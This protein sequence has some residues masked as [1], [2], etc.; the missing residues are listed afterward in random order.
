MRLLDR[1]IFRQVFASCLGAI[2][3]FTFV[4][5]T[6]NVLKQLLTLLLTG[7]LTFLGA[8]PLIGLLVPFVV[9]YT[10][11]MGL[12]CG[13]LLVL[14]RLSAESETVAMRAAGLSL[15]RI[16]APIYALAIAAGIAAVAINLYYMP[17][18]ITKQRQELTRIVR[19]D[20]LKM[21]VPKTFVRDFKN[22]VVYVTER[23]GEE[24]RDVWVWELDKEQRVS[25][26]L[27][28]ESGRIDLDEANNQL[29]ITLNHTSA[30]VRS[31]KDPE[32][33][34][35]PPVTA[36]FDTTSRAISLDALFG[37]ST[38]K[39]K[40]DWF[41][42]GELKAEEVRL[43]KPDPTVPDQTRLKQ[44]TKVRLSMQEKLTTAFTVFSFALIAVPL[45]ITVSR[46]ETSANLGVALILALSYYFMSML[47]QALEDVPQLRPDLLLWLPNVVFIFVAIWLYRRTERA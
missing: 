42:W 47:V 32:N 21:I 14:G 25:R 4:L 38:F 28:A 2:G 26:F 33:Y 45:G 24:V 15:A 43:S 8:I 39:R 5:L 12:L 19:G 16:C 35:E 34:R 6:A 20:P 10:L 27:R 18:A 9:V 22:C 36:Y 44:L 37:Q 29:V 7:Q 41:T 40:I 17:L 1:Y 46:R 30:E 23:K 13:I 31:T 11:P 3:F